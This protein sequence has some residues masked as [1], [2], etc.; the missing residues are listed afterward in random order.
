M[1]PVIS[2]LTVGVLSLAAA[3]VAQ[4]GPPSFTVRCMH[5]GGPQILPKYGTYHFFLKESL[6]KG[7][8]CSIPGQPCD[9]TGRTATTIT[10]QTPGEN[11]DVV[12]IDLRD[13]TIQHRKANGLH[14]TFAC[15][16]ISG[17]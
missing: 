15:R 12:T 4:A 5:T 2:A 10:F 9:I 1:R 8:A 6:V 17:G 16:Q 7:Y 11:P 14:A 3:S 13:G